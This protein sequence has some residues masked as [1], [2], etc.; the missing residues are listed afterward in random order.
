MAIGFDR[1][2]SVAPDVMFRELGGESVLL[3]LKTERY[4]GL[5]E[6]GT[7]MW[8]V[9]IGS[10]S[11]QAAYAELAAEYDV[12][13]DRLKKDLEELIVKLVAEGLIVVGAENGAGGDGAA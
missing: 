4:L 9:L 3:D 7:R 6:V 5:D 12:E 2:V 11:I 13:S 1:R 8:N 10:P